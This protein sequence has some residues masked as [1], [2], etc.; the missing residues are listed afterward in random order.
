MQL[1]FLT[2]FKVENQSGQDIWVTPIGT[3]GADGRRSRL[4]IFITV[5]PAFHAIKTG[6][7]RLKDG[8]TLKIKYDW[9]D[10]NFSEIAVE[11]K[12]GQFYQL[13]V[14]PKPT[15]N[16]Y[17]P[18]ESRH[19]SIPPLETLPSIQPAVLESVARPG[20][21]WIPPLLTFFG[22]IALVVLYWRMIAHFLKDKTDRSIASA[23]STEG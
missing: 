7:F 8:G 11:A 20:R 14:D 1:A 23:N 3:I 4:P 19:F 12:G 22:S 6:R 2:S 17:H 21:M 9:D 10:I 15:E 13:I 5:I 18:P 16:Q